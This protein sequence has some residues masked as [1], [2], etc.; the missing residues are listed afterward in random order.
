MAEEDVAQPRKVYLLLVGFV[1][2]S[3]SAISLVL[4]CEAG[5]PLPPFA[6]YDT[7]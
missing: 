3:V 7:V 1:P 6:L 4:V 5:A 2:E